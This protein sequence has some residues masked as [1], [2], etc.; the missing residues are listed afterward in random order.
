MNETNFKRK[1]IGIFFTFNKIWI[2]GL[3]YIINL[4]KAIK[5]LPD[6]ERPEIYLFYSPDNVSFLDEIKQAEYPYIH[7]ISF[8]DKM[9]GKGA[10]LR[11]LIFRRNSILDKIVNQYQL[12]G[13]FP[14]NDLPVKPKF[15]REVII[16]SW[17]PDFQH[18]VF[19][20]YFSKMNLILREKR[21]KWVFKNTDFLVLSS[22]HVYSHFKQF[23]ENAGN[24]RVKILHF[25]S[26]VHDEDKVDI[27]FLMD[28]YQIRSPYFLVS[29]Q[30][31]AHKNHILVFKAIKILKERYPELL[32]VFTGRME[33]YR[34][35]A[36]IQSLKNYVFQNDIGGN[37]LFLGVI[38]RIEQLS[39]M[40]NAICV[41]QPSKFEGWSTVIEDAKSLQV[42][43]IASDFEVHV[44][45]LQDYAYYFGQNNPNELAT[46]M[47]GY[48]TG[49][50]KRKIFPDNYQ[51][52][53]LEFARDF[54]SIF[55]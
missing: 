4:A 55:N 47:E 17:F 48:L 32:V 23:A 19:P 31:Y 33:D 7:F 1:E 3:I 34:N 40:K 28:K 29:N 49:S 24:V 44:E 43:C 50:I 22:N 13:V 8:T 38:K 54:M 21:F 51:E 46:L 2:G 30:F 39:L 35:P 14:V 37:C 5:T 41:I 11:S 45:Q 12:N 18:K 53:V 6:E 16:T 15:N 26:M 20:E 42:P 10:Y 36:F 52:R 25:V 27:E 9:N